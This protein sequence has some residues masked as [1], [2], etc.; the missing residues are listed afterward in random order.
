M[1]QSRFHTK[2]KISLFAGYYK[3]HLRLFILDLICAIGI[4]VIDLSFPMV[5]RFSLQTLLPSGEYRF[6][7]LL[8]IGLVF[9]FL[10]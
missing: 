4:A 10:I 7:G 9:A 1:P 3:P 5:S 8:M 6:F 2:S